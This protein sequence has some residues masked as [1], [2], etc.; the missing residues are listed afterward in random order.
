MADTT[1]NPY[2]F[3]PD[4]R[5]RFLD[6]IRA[7]HGRFSACKAIGIHPETMRRYARNSPEFQEAL[8]QAEEEACEP[9]EAKLYE[10]AKAGEP[11]AVKEWLTKRNKARWGDASKQL[12]INVSGTVELEGGAGVRAIASRVAELQRALE[13]RQ[14]VL[15]VEGGDI[16]DAY[17]IEDHPE[18]D[19][20]GEQLALPPP[21]SS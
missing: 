1:E 21:S 12:D 11:W 8:A 15:E 13:E 6:L 7:G 14:R 17:V 5:A 10:L 19:E 3:G 9:V 4:V 16:V 20:G 18:H 2:K